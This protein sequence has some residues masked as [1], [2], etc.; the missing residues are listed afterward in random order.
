MVGF[1]ARSRKVQRLQ[2]CRGLFYNRSILD[3][4]SFTDDGMLD[5]DALADFGIRHDHTVLDDGVFTDL[6]TAKYDGALGFS[7][8]GALV[9][10][11]AVRVFRIACPPPKVWSSMHGYTW[12]NR[13]SPE[14]A[15][16]G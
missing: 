6:R 5:M 1:E 16:F 15:R 13:I 3:E 8:E 11:Q 4:R 9:M 7:F 12:A 10:N 2:R 14:Q